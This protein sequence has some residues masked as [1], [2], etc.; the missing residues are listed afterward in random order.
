M[1]LHEM[2]RASNDDFI[3]EIME[4]REKGYYEEVSRLYE[5]ERDF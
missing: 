5:A 1:V 2:V 3:R 4:M